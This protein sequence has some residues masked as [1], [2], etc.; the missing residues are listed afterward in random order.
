MH[1]RSQSKKGEGEFAEEDLEIGS[2]VWLKKQRE[3]GAMVDEEGSNVE[4]QLANLSTMFQK[5]SLQFQHFQEQQYRKNESETSEGKK[6]DNDDTRSV[7]Q[8][9][10]L[11][12]E[13]KFDL[14]TFNGEVNAEKLDHWIKQIEVYCRIQKI[15]RDE[16]RIQLATLKMSGNALFW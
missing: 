11:K 6:I 7:F 8:S 5:M 10:P 3:L 13:V 16:D 1:T 9:S 4:K 12:L 2:R 15:E 14:P